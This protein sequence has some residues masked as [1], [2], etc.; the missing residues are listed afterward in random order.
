MIIVILGFMG[1]CG[2]VFTLHFLNPGMYTPEQIEHELGIHAIG[3]IPKLPPK[4]EPYDYLR[5]KPHSG[6]VEALNSLKISLKLSDPDA[7]VKVIQ[8]TSSVPEEGK[9]SLVL[10]LAVVMAK[11]GKKVLVIDADLRRSSLDKTLGLPK[12]GPG[13]TDYVMAQI[14]SPDE[15]VHPHE[16]AG[17]DYMR[18]GDAHYASATDIFTSNRMQRIVATL[19]E[20]YDF[21]LFDTPPVMAV[22]DARVI[23]QL[24]DKT[25]F[26]VRWDKT[27]RKVARASLELLRKAD[28][29]IAGVVLQQVNLKRYGRYGYGDSGYY[30]YGPARRYYTN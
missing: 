24:A 30:H 13:L 29:N 21:V 28:A 22:A 27:P 23:G 17:I 14:D 2:L 16:E 10:S 25:L 11:E 12:E 20:R 1:S 5:K 7:R 26:V 3:M 6:Y 15:Y 8:I 4:V 19:K 18:T 9:S